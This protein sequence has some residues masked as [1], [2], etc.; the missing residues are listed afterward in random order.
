MQRERIAIAGNLVMAMI[1][2]D[3]QIEAALNTNGMQASELMG[4][5]VLVES[6]GEECCQWGAVIPHRILGD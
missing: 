6:S 3:E 2:V 4:A 5:S 1:A